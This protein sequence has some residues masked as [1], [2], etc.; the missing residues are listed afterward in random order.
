MKVPAGTDTFSPYFT[1]YNRKPDP[2]YCPQGY[3]GE[4]RWEAKVQANFVF[5]RC[6]N[7]E[8][9]RNKKRFLW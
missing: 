6:I 1:D 4:H 7:C 3:V 2:N 9:I 8:K 5:E